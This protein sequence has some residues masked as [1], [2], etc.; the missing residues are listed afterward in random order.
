[1]KRAEAFISATARALAC[2][3][4]LVC[5]QGFAADANSV[6]A[7]EPQSVMVAQAATPEP[8]PT[9]APAAAVQTEC[10]RLAA[11]PVPLAPTA[12]AVAKTPVD[13]SHAIEV[14]TTEVNA[15]PGSA[16][17][18]YE[19]GRSYFQN[20]NYLEAVRHYRIAADAGNAQAMS[21]LGF[22]YVQGLG[23]I[24]NDQMAFE[25]FNK[26]AQMGNANAMQNV[27]SMYA[28]GRFV[29]QDQSKALE[30]FEKSIEA[31]NAGALGA[32]GVV[33]FNGN[34]GA[35]DY[36]VAAQYFQQAADLGDG[37]SLKFLAIMYERGLLGPV[38][39]EKAGALRAKAQQVDPQSQ[40]PNVP[41]PQ[42]VQAQKPRHT[43]SGGGNRGGGGGG[44]GSDSGCANTQF[45][46]GTVHVSRWR[47]M[48][49]H[50][51]RCWPF[52]TVN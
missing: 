5:A 19:L 8:A 26:A 48:A 37:Y 15:N 34:G 29:K 33:Y 43:G 30:W 38:D 47:G 13:W 3:S 52:C 40:D 9:A 45:C 1:M 25:L 46:T 28:G 10:D 49:T 24:N 36:K 42:Q 27:G 23:A 31:G 17:L 41:P 20:K 44:G 6:A 16:R 4:A 32:A 14:C 21:D 22:A 35:P 7:R 2:A 12:P 39:L 51:P 50:L 18:Q 11:P